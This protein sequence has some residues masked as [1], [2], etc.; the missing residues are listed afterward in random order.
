MRRTL[1]RKRQWKN[2]NYQADQRSDLTSSEQE[3]ANQVA[4]DVLNDWLLQNGRDS[5][6]MD[7]ALSAGRQVEIY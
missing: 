7:E 6:E 2:D 3:E 4:L 5:I 1:R